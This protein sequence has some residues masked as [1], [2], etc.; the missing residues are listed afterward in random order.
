MNELLNYLATYGWI[1]TLIAIGGVVILGI[2]K[3]FNAFSKLEEQARHVIY[4]VITTGFSLIGSTIYLVCMHAFNL[5]AF[6]TIASALFVL[7]QAFYN[8]FAVTK[9]KDVFKMLLDFIFKH[10][11]NK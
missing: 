11:D 2:L 10:T 1:L 6:L 3:Y 8:I 5:Q 7:D 4:I 9:V